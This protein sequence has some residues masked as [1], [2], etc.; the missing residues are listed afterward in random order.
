MTKNENPY[1]FPYAYLYGQAPSL[2]VRHN[3]GMTL[4]DY[5]AGHALTGFLTTP[6]QHCQFD[7]AA[8]EAYEYADAMLRARSLPTKKE[9]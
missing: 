7:N 6:G 1:A 2:K 3:D 5:F 4:R 9:G 8:R